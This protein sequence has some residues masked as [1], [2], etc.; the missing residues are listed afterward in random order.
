MATNGSQTEVASKVME[1]MRS[2]LP[3]PPQFSDKLEER[4]YLKFRLAQYN[5]YW[6]YG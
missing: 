3:K 1:R 6:D 2:S 4:A 5:G